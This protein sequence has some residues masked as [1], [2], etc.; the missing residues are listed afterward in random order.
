LPFSC[1]PG[2]FATGDEPIGGGSSGRR[3]PRLRLR[4]ARRASARHRRLDH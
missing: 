1:P 4:V 3:G 2:A